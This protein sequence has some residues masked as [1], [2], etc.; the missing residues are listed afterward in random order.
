MDSNT[1]IQDLQNI[2][3][4]SQAIRALTITKKCRWWQK[5]N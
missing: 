2:I 3:V 5:Y 4:D 1:M